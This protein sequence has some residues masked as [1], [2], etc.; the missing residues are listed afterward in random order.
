MFDANHS[1]YEDLLC[2][3]FGHNRGVREVRG[4]RSGHCF[5]RIH[6]LDWRLFQLCLDSFASHVRR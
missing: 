2:V 4:S 6:F 3:F 1:G 5:Y